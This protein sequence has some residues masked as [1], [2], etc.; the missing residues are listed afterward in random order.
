MPLQVKKEEK[1][2]P[3]ACIYSTDLMHKPPMA[4]KHA[5]GCIQAMVP[6]EKGDDGFLHAVFPDGTE[7]VF[8]LPN[9]VMDHIKE[10]H[11]WK[12]PM[13]MKALRAMKA[14]KAMKVKKA[15][16]AMKAMKA[17]PEPEA[18]E[19][20]VHHEAPVAGVSKMHSIMWYKSAKSI[21]IRQRTG[22]KK[23]IL[24]FGGALA[25]QTEETMKEI[26]K[27]VI[28]MIESGSSLPVAKQHGQR[29]ACA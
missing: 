12:K 29:R 2:K 8:D 26:G 9:L 5:E 20:E 28:G 16:K 7:K 4:V 23:Q 1:P 13:A 22:E 6:L 14:M 10:E 3:M 17:P 19:P 18:P 11:A 25:T 27:E 24:S 21:G 15:M